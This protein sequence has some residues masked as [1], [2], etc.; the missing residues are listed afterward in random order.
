LL[1]YHCFVLVVDNH[2]VSRYRHPGQL[3][4]ASNLC[5]FV[6][7]QLYALCGR[8]FVLHLQGLHSLF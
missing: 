5:L 2:G 8:F 3:I 1:F 7:T 4:L 6:L